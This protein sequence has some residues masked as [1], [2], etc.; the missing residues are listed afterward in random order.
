MV[1]PSEDIANSGCPSLCTICMSV[2][3][4]LASNR[5]PRERGRGAPGADG[6][7]GGRVGRGEGRGLG[8]GRGGKR[9]V[10]LGWEVRLIEEVGLSWGMGVCV[11]DGEGVGPGVAVATEVADG[12]TV[13]GEAGTGPHPARFQLASRSA[14]SSS[15]AGRCIGVFPLTDQVQKIPEN[16][17]C[18]VI[19]FPV[20]GG[21]DF[22]H[23]PALLGHPR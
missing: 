8:L 2:R 15:S 23:V 21:D 1:R 5:Q 20:A 13:T 14:R 11:S 16:A 3:C 17:A 9:G 12:T 10:G 19:V 7:G 4:P 18:Q 22:L 6:R